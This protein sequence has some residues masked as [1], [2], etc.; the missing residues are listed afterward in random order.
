MGWKFANFFQ[1]KADCV[2]QKLLM[3]KAAE[4]LK[5]QQMLK[6]QERQR[7][8]Q[9]RI[10]PL[11]D[12]DSASHGFPFYTLNKAYANPCRSPMKTI[13]GKTC[14]AY[15]CARTDLRDGLRAPKQNVLYP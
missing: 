6:E 2:L 5:E 4:D 11:P 9:E 14:Y 7:V 3:M 12:L 10:L 8:L 1:K 15:Y 13:K